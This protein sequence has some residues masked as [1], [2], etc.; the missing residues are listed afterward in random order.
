MMGAGVGV[1]LGSWASVA[2]LSVCPWNLSGLDSL[3]SIFLIL[4]WGW[5]AF[6]LSIPAVM[7]SR[8]RACE[9]GLAATTPFHRH[10]EV[11][12]T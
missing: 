7:R 8:G 2:A 9:L 6:I 11:Q 4:D 12:T 5:M 10:D 3:G 1:G